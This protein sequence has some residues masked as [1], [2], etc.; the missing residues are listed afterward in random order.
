MSC[1]N[2][3]LRTVTQIM[4]TSSV[5]AISDSIDFHCIPTSYV[6]ILTCLRS[7]AEAR[8]SAI[9]QFQH[10]VLHCN[11]NNE[12]FL[13]TSNMGPGGRYRSIDAN[14]YISLGMCRLEEIFRDPIVHSP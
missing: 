12:H 1:S 11:T 13:F 6:L 14:M 3:L 9:E 7:Q 5:Q 8:R 4:N 2:M 10:V